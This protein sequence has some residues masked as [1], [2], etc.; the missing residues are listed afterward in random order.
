MSEK[1]KETHLMNEAPRQAGTDRREE[2][3]KPELRSFKMSDAEFNFPNLGIDL[4]G[5]S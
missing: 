4:C 3:V 5:F 2:W 1:P